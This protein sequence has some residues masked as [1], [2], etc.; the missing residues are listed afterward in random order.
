MFATYSYK[1]LSLCRPTL[2]ILP[3]SCGISNHSTEIIYYDLETT[4][5]NPR[6]KQ[7]GIEILQ[8]G[9]ISDTIGETFQQYMLPTTP[10]PWTATNVHGLFLKKKEGETDWSSLYIKED[11]S[12]RK[13][14]AVDKETGL[15]RFVD[16]LDSF[17]S[18]ITLTGYNSHNYDDWVLCHGLQGIV[19]KDDLKIRRLS[20]VAKITR[21]ILREKLQT[22]KWNLG[23]AVSH[24]LERRQ[25][26]AHGALS[27]AEDARDLLNKIANIKNMTAKGVL[28]D[29]GN[30]C[31]KETTTSFTP[32][33]H[34]GRKCIGQ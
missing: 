22:R 27:D 1:L 23:F 5:L 18:N 30:A 29:C 7:K 24:L 11:G 4:G 19:D 2:L 9:A 28:E 20:D 31:S 12:S 14:D 13:V 33:N 3:D 17:Q 8:L 21:P 25:R 6:Q 10:I 32:S 26:L 34:P 15:K 16:W